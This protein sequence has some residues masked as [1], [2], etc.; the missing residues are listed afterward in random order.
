MGNRES[1]RIPANRVPLI[2]TLTSLWLVR[3]IRQRP[4]E[5]WFAL[6]ALTILF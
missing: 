6:P 2:R 3:G 1:A 5:R 4:A